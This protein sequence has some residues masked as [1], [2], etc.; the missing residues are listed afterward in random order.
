M[1][2]VRALDQKA[3]TLARTR[4]IRGNAR[5][6]ILFGYPEPLIVRP[7]RA[8]LLG[9]G[10]RAHDG[11]DQTGRGTPVRTHPGTPC[12]RDLEHAVKHRVRKAARAARKANR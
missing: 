4:Q 2:G 10:G 3:T 12:V 9:V 6:Q 1:S 8:H 5:L 7:E 11:G